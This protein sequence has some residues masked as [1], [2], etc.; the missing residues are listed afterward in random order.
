MWY[1]SGDM[2]VEDWRKSKKKWKP[3]EEYRNEKEEKKLTTRGGFYQK[4][5]VCN[6]SKIFQQSL[7]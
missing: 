4:E 3:C 5:Q 7:T 1:S 6:N 2:F